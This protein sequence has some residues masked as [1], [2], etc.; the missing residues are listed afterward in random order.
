MKNKM[1]EKQWQRYEQDG[2]VKLGRLSGDNELSALQDEIDSIMLGEANVPYDDMMM[3]LDSDTGQYGDMGEMSDGFKGA[4]LNYRKIE[5][6]ELDAKFI[7][8]IQYPLFRDICDRTYGRGGPVDCFRAMFMN[9]PAHAGTLLPWHQDRWTSLDKDPQIT[10]WTALDAATATNGCIQII[11]GSHGLGV[12][13]PEHNS[14][15]LTEAQAEA[16]VEEDRIVYL[17]L[18]AGEAVLLHNWVL[19]RSD[20]NATDSPRRAFSVCYMDGT[21]KSR[22][23]E[24]FRRVFGE[25]ALSPELLPAG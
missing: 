8:Y 21:T 20:T 9:K 23:G 25:N 15:F 1:T 18:E 12:I 13:N 3:Q 22:D 2:Y 5:D 24:T 7:K 4:S 14:A 6:L 10:V 17:E 16:V 19:H 11:P